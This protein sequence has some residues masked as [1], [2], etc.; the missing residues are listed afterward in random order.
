MLKQ[1]ISEINNNLNTNLNISRLID[2]EVLVL[3]YNEIKNYSKKQLNDVIVIEKDGKIY[4]Y[5]N[6]TNNYIS[7]NDSIEKKELV[8]R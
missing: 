8:K 4:N 1:I 5:S 2:D 3:N 7:N 6:E